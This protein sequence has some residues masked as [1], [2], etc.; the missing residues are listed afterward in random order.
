VDEVYQLNPFLAVKDTGGSNGESDVKF[1]RMLRT[2]RFVV[3]LPDSVDLPERERYVYV[4]ER[5]FLENY[6][7]V[8][9]QWTVKMADG[10]VQN[11]YK[12]IALHETDADV[13]RDPDDNIIRLE[14]VR[15]KE[16]AILGFREKAAIIL[17]R[18]Q[19]RALLPKKPKPTVTKEEDL[20]PPQEMTL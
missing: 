17:S 11:P 5:I 2:E 4:V 19:H 20:P 12:F 1:Q 14:E 18:A 13:R 6:E 15:V 9:I 16:S 7:N 8:F 3:D 10:S